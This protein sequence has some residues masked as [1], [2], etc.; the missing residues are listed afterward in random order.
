LNRSLSHFLQG[1]RSGCYGGFLLGCYE[2]DQ[3]EYQTICK[4]GTGFSDEA[5]QTHY[6][7]LAQEASM[8]PKSYYSYDPSLAPD[9]WFAPVQVWEV[10]CADLSVSPVHKAAVGLVDQ[11]RGISLRFPRFLRI[12][13]DKKVEDATNAEQVAEM[14]RNQ[15]AVKSSSTGKDDDDYDF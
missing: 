7:T 11:D 15:D 4:I 12:R 8:K 14:Y 2:A 13:Q 3:E 5:L 9:V 1:K 6:E 10:K